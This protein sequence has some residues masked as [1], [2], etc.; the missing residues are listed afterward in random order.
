VARTTR[1]RRRAFGQEQW[2]D[3]ELH[4]SP[5]LPMDQRYRITASVPDESVTMRIESHTDDRL[6]LEAGLSRNETGHRH[7][8]GRLLWRHP[9]LTARVRPHLHRG[10]QLALKGTPIH[11]HRVAPG[12]RRIGRPTVRSARD[13]ARSEVCSRWPDASTAERW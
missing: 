10:R 12:P 6:V 11:R 8:L 3:K 1:L 7:A 9:M 5:F 4:V 2:F 13:A